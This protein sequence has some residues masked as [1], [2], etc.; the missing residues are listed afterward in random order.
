MQFEI[1]RKKRFLEVWDGEPHLEYLIEVTIPPLEFIIGPTESRK[2]LLGI[3]K[4]T[5]AK[6]SHL[7]DEIHKLY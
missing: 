4:D 6:F 1:E 7:H 3:H 2:V 5:H